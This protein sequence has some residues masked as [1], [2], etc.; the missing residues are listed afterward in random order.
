MN[1]GHSS[2]VLSSNCVLPFLKPG[3]VCF[4]DQQPELHK[5]NLY[6]NHLHKMVY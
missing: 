3:F 1:V 4:S 6:I 2:A 5:T